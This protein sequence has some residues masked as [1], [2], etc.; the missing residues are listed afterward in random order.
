MAMQMRFLQT[1]SDVG[2]EN[3][4]KLVF[5]LP[6]DLITYRP[7]QHVLAEER[8][9]HRRSTGGRAKTIVGPGGA[10]AG[11]VAS[12]Q[13]GRKSVRRVR[14]A[15]RGELIGRPIGCEGGV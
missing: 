13:P 9:R 10:I 11:T 2:S 7:N 3:N 4:A 15:R 14:A 12:G 5:P 8:S 1:L 6:V